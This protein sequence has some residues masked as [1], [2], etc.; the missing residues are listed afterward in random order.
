MIEGQQQFGTPS[1]NKEQLE[2]IKQNM[3]NPAAFKHR[4]NT[5]NTGYGFEQVLDEQN[6]RFLYQ[7]NGQAVNRPINNGLYEPEQDHVNAYQYVAP[8]NLG[9]QQEQ[10]KG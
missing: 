7:K 10:Y 8:G 3:N 1:Y 4:N 9:R 6:H 2:F 5:Q